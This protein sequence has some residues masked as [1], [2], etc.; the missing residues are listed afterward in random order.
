MVEEK[1]EIERLAKGDLVYFPLKC[2]FAVGRVGWSSYFAYVFPYGWYITSA[3]KDEWIKFKFWGRV[4]YLSISRASDKGIIGVEI[5]G[6]HVIDVDAYSPILQE[7]YLVKIADDLEP[8]EHIVKLICTGAKNPA[9]TGITTLITGMLVERQ[10]N[11]FYPYFPRLSWIDVVEVCRLHGQ[12]AG[13]WY[14]LK[15]KSDVY[16]NLR[17]SIWED[18]SEV[19]VITQAADDKSVAL[20]GLCTSAFLYGFDGTSWVRLRVDGAKNLN[21]RL[22]AMH[23]FDL[24]NYTTPLGAGASWTS[25]WIWASDC[26]KVRGTFIADTTT[27]VRLEWSSNGVDVD[28]VETYSLPAPGTGQVV[29]TDVKQDYIRVVIVNT[30]TTT[31]QTYIRAKLFRTPI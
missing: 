7:P 22:R 5:D 11:P 23:F 1:I 20:R 10:F 24:I 26:G 19:E 15:V 18:D 14:P 31:A 30:D 25:G 6:K 16:P 13:A 28:Y 4:L 27:E 3:T 8:R 17:V 12:Y 29:V 21:V 2:E 9:S